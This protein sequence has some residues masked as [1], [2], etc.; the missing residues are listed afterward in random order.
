VPFDLEPRG[1][2]LGEISWALV[3]LK[4]LC[5]HAAIEVVMVALPGE[6]VARGLAWDLDDTYE[7][8]VCEEFER[9]VHG[10]HA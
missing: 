5:A 8:F 7:P 9:A 1:A 10:R 4:D 6:F 3:H 2:K